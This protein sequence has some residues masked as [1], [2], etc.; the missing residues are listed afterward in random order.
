MGYIIPHC[1]YHGPAM[2]FHG[3]SHGIAHRENSSMVCS[4]G[5]HVSFTK[6]HR[7]MW[8]WSISA[9]R[10]I[11]CV[12]WHAP[13][14]K[15]LLASWFHDVPHERKYPTGHPMHPLAFPVMLSMDKLLHGMCHCTSLSLNKTNDPM[16]CPMGRPWQLYHAHL[17]YVTKCH[18]PT[19]PILAWRVPSAS[20]VFHH[21]ISHG[22]SHGLFHGSWC[23]PCVP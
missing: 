12:P 6:G 5:F 21:R 7:M 13:W 4:I 14:R 17:W 1:K 8:P 9:M 23:I 11:C 18:Y 3:V 22:V 16:E 15:S 2:I 19:G 10:V 20:M